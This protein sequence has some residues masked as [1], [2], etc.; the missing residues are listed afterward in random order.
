MALTGEQF[1]I[2]DGDHEATIVEIG[3]GLR[4]YVRGATPI[5]F[6]YGDD[7]LPPKCCG[8]V[9]VPWPNRLRGGAYTFDGARYQL[10]LTEPA[11]R[12]AIH[13]LGRWAR[14]NCIRHEPTV[15]VMVLDIPPQIGWPFE[16]RVE[17]T[18]TISATDGLTV[19]T[20]ARNAGSRRAP[21]GAG[22]HPY[23]SVGGGSLPEITLRIP[24]TQRL[25]VDGVQ[26]PIGHQDV[27][28]SAYDFRAGKRLREMRL[29]DAFTGIVGDGSHGTVEMSVGGRGAR[30]WFDPAFAYVQVFTPDLLARGLP[31]IAVEPMTCPAD[32]F[33]TGA[34]LIVL[35]PG[36]QWRGAWGIQPI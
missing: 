11:Q 23:L 2:R 34:G 29:D 30:V 10:A 13:G 32:A 4:R 21:F 19:S 28:G 14:W 36:S 5:T 1:V 15:C 3:G 18:Y 31:G 9:L 6:D 27:A 25:V 33:N 7:E 8:A 26:I 17:V 24:A 20:V 12:N 22:F 16:V 35:E